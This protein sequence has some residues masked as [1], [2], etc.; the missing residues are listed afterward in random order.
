MRDIDICRQCR[1]FRLC[2][3]SCQCHDIDEDDDYTEEDYKKL[4]LIIYRPG[5]KEPYV[6]WFLHWQW[7]KCGQTAHSS[8]TWR[9]MT[10]CKGGCE[11]Y[12][13]TWCQELKTTIR[14][15]ITIYHCKR[16]LQ[17]SISQDKWHWKPIPNTCQRALEQLVLQQHRL[18]KHD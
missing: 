7:V 15:H 11:T 18:D 4:P 13:P 10:I 1:S 3:E 12:G 8:H 14:N 17:P 6:C 16:E 5:V 2:P 9:S